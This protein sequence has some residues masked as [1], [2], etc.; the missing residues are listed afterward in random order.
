LWR[1]GLESLAVGFCSLFAVT[2]IISQ[3][4][5]EGKEHRTFSQSLFQEAESLLCISQLHAVPKGEHFHPGAKNPRYG[6]LV[7]LFI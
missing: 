7:H 6:V 5:L 2:L 3:G 1:C 4:P